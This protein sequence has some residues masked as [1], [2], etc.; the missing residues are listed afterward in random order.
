LAAASTALRKSFRV[1]CGMFAKKFPSAPLIGNTRA[2][3]ERMN[4]P[5]T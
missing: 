3:S 4:A 5:P 1:H 2:L